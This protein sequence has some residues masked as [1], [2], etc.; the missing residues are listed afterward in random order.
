VS[1]PDLIN[2]FYHMKFRK[3]PCL[4]HLVFLL[5]PLLQSFASELPNILFIAVD[6]LGLQSPL[7]GQEQMVTPGLER[8]ASQGVTFTRAYVSVPVCG[9]SRASLLSGAR[10]TSDRFWDYKT[11]KDV[12]LPDV[13]SLPKWFKEHGYTTISNGKIYHHK[14]D[15]LDAWSEAPWMPEHQGVGWKCYLKPESIAMIEANKSIADP[16]SNMGPSTEDADVP[17]N[18]YPDGMLADKVI[19]DLKR[20]AESGEPFFLSAGFWKPH[21]PFNAPKKYWDLYDPE[22]I[23][24]TDNPFKPKNAPDACMHNFEELRRM[25]GDTPMKGPIPD[26][27]ALRLTHGYYACVSYVDAQIDKVLSALDEAGLAEN[28]IVILWGDHGFHLGEHGLW[29][30][31]AC[32]HRVMNAPLLVKAPGIEGNVKT[33]AITEFIDIYPTLCDLAGI[34]LPDHLDGE[35]FLCEMKNPDNHFKDYA[36]SRYKIGESIISNHYMYTEFTDRSG[37]PRGRMLYDHRSDPAENLNVS[38]EPAYGDVV[39]SM[40]ASLLEVRNSIK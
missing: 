24:L 5:A 27:L 20:F 31:H 22:E 3:L 40:H 39:E 13:P 38:E 10:P 29:C 37:S 34:P 9:A 14:D 18:M 36:Y 32:F 26:D 4:P 2:D 15:D 28:T 17:D 35:S 1:F 7:F 33:S 12:D 11:R 16:D 21:L 30:K 23:E 8:L 25:Y 19:E 6:D